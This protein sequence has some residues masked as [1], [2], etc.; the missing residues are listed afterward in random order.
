MSNVI[1]R[2]RHKRQRLERLENWPAKGRARKQVSVGDSLPEG[3]VP[4]CNKHR[5]HYLGYA[6]HHSFV[7]FLGEIIRVRRPLSSVALPLPARLQVIVCNF[8]LF[9]FFCR[10]C[11]RYNTEE[12]KAYQRR[13]RVVILRSDER[14]VSVGEGSHAT[15]TMAMQEGGR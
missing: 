3:V 8:L 1:H 9:R 4:K 2:T 15:M 12:T 5:V 13:G 6:T 10:S 11:T 14:H 7:E